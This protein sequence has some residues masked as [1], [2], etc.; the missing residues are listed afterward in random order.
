MSQAGDPLLGLE[1][2]LGRGTSQ[3]DDRSRPNDPDL[4]DE[5]RAARLDLVPK[6]RA[7]VG[8]SALEDVRDVDLLAREA[9]GP[10]HVLELLPGTADERPAGAV[11]LFARRFADEHHLR[12]GG[13]FAEDRLRVRR[14]GRAMRTLAIVP[15]A[16][17]RELNGLRVALRRR[18][19]N[20]DLRRLVGGCVARF[21]RIVWQAYRRD[22]KVAVGTHQR[23]GEG[24]TTIRF[25]RGHRSSAPSTRGAR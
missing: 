11:F 5:V 18:G 10:D 12:V 7:I 1:Q 13:A 15:L 3:R 8:W 24:S 6:R 20:V 2:Q 17:G 25:A 16:K 19:S 22:A 9:H 14:R 4:F 21:G 23:P